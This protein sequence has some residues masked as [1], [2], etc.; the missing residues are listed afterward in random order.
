MKVYDASL[1][2]WG[3]FTEVSE[4]RNTYNFSVLLG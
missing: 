2:V 4:H 1:K 3:A